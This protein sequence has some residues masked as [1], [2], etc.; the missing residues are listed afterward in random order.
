MAGDAVAGFNDSQ[1][2]RDNAAGLGGQAAPG[3]ERATRW[4]VHRAW[5]VALQYDA[6]ALLLL[7]VIGDGNR[8]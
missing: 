3:M 2:R 7:I 4:L 8:G 6:G 5:N 1:F